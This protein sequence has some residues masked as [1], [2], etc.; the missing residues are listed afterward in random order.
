VT[1]LITPQ[2]GFVPDASDVM[3]VAVRL[4]TIHRK[5]WNSLS[6]TLEVMIAH[7]RKAESLIPVSVWYC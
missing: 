5:L 2:D 4:Q 7:A 3:F 1:F 6:S